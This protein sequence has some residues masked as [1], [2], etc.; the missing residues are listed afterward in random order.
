MYADGSWNDVN[1]TRDGMCA[2]WRPYIPGDTPTPVTGVVPATAPLLSTA[3]QFAYY[4]TTPFRQSFLYSMLYRGRQYFSTASMPLTSC[5]TTCRN[6]LVGGGHMLSIH[7]AEENDVIAQLFRATRRRL[8]DAGS[9]IVWLLMTGGSDAAEE[10]TCGWLGL[11]CAW[12][13]AGESP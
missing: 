10:G 5:N 4:F 3:E 2:C 12:K 8:Y 6:G 1:E 13:S 9:G 7:S 11:R